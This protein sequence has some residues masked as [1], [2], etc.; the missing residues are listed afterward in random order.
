[1]FLALVMGLG[2][3]IAQSSEYSR[4]RPDAGDTTREE[5]DHCLTLPRGPSTEPFEFRLP[6]PPHPLSVAFAGSRNE[7][8]NPACP[9][10]RLDRPR[11]H[12]V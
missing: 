11:L 12:K 9:P 7:S 1:M 3:G 10:G 4:G 8:A 6:S 2:L 5:N